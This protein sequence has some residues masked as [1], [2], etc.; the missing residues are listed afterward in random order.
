MTNAFEQHGIDHLSASSLNLY[1]A[2]PAMWVQ[3][4]LF[5]FRSP[6]SASMARGIAAEAGIEHGLFN[7]DLT[8]DECIKLALEAFDLRMALNGDPNREKERAAVPGIVE[9]GLGHLRLYGMPEKPE[10][11]RQHRIEVRADTLPVPIIGYLDFEFPQHGIVLDLKTQLRLQSSISPSHARQGAIYVRARG[12][13]VDMRFAYA[14][15][16]KIAVY[17]LERAAERWAEVLNV[18]HRLER[19]LSLSKDRDELA[20][21]VAPNYD[22]FYWNEA[23]ARQRG[24]QLYGF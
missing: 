3:Q 4:Y 5:G 14:T 2:E 1:C 20:G 19:F 16:K 24:L 18:A 17:P 12:N 23:S 7:P 13:N 6:P 15:P 9:Q 11:G 21:I 10:S 22:S 8:W